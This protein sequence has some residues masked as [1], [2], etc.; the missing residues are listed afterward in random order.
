MKSLVLNIIIFLV[1]GNIGMAQSRSP[2]IEPFACSIKVG[3]G[4][5]A[6][7]GYLVVPENRQKING[8][9]I[10]IPFFFV[11]KLGADSTK[12][13]SL[14]TTGGPG[15]STIANFDQITATSGFLKYGS[16]IAFDQ[17]GTK[18]AIP[19]LDCPEVDEAIRQAYRQNQPKEKFVLAA[20]KAC[21]KK[22]IDQGIDLSAYN[23]IESAADIS[24]LR[25]ALHID[26]LTL[27]GLSYSGGLMLTV[28]RNHP[29]G[30]KSMVLS[31]SLPGFV[32]YEEQGLFNMNEALAQIFDNCEADSTNKVLYANLRER[33]QQYFSQITNQRFD[34]TYTEKAS[35]KIYKTSYG[36]QEL[37]DAIIGCIDNTRLKSVPFVIQEIINGKHEPYVKAVLDD[38]FSGNPSLSLGMRY[39]VY[40]SEQIA[41]SAPSLIEKQ[42]VI[43]PWFAGY[44]FNNVSHPIC[45]CWQVKP[46]AQVAKTPV[47][48][49]IPVLLSAGDA[50]PWCR[51]FYNQL[52]KRT[53]P[54]S[55]LML[56]HNRAHPAGYTVEGVDYLEMFMRNPYQKLVSKSKDLLI[57]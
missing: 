19:S 13:I 22:F 31:S 18:K 14:Y 21:R 45:D 36:K 48:S 24:D 5:I 42:S 23:T 20:T 12:N 41:Y 1:L 50:D 6:R 38:I 40:C 49:N 15:Y 29:E 9:Q 26:S 43:L 2:Q 39:A 32:N 52:I 51:P 11:R 53:M 47:Y 57:E 34:M 28:A 10:K 17:R 16:F 3:P 25:K 30:I 27:V 44:T 33:F 56:I 37:L 55:Q 54:N 46:V 35:N 7:C 8:R 4:V